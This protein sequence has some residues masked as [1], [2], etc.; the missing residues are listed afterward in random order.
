MPFCQL[1]FFIIST[2]VLIKGYLF[3]HVVPR[4]DD[5]ELR[6]LGQNDIESSTSTSIGYALDEW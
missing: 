1:P 3:F 4:W 5:T 6:K 2:S